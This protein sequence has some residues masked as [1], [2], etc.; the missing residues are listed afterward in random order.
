MEPTSGSPLSASL[1]FGSSHYPVQSFQGNEALSQPFHFTLLLQ[2]SDLSD[3]SAVLG[4]PCRLVLGSQR[5]ISAIITQHRLLHPY[6]PE[7]L[8][9]E[10]ELQ[11]RLSLLHLSGQPRVYTNLSARDIASM[12]LCRHG[13]DKSQL[14]FQDAWPEE[15]IIYPHWV[16]AQDESDFDF[17]Q[18]VLA[19]EGICYF[20]SNPDEGNDEYI[21][22]HDN[23]FLHPS[24]GTPFFVSSSDGLSR[25]TLDSLYKLNIKESPAS[26]NVTYSDFDP[27][28][29]SR[30]MTA[31]AGT[32]NRQV[33]V[34]GY[35]AQSFRQLQKAARHHHEQL[36]MQQKVLNA[37]SHNP[38]LM[39]GHT[40]SIMKLPAWVGGS[41]FQ[42]LELTHHF[43]KGFYHNCLTFIPKT[44]PVRP[45]PV[46]R[47]AGHMIHTA[48][49]HSDD[50]LPYLDKAGNYT[51]Y[52]HLHNPEGRRDG[53]QKAARLTPYGGNAVNKAMG[54][55]FPLRRQ[56]EVLV[57]YLHN[58]FNQPI[59]QNSPPNGLN[60]APVTRDNSWQTMLKT[61]YGQYLEFCDLK[62]KE[63]ITLANAD[64]RNR[65][66]FKNHQT[67]TP[68]IILACERGP[69]AFAAQTNSSLSSD[70][71]ITF[72]IGKDLLI[73]TTERCE[74]TAKD[75][76]LQA[77]THQLEAEDTISID[78]KRHLEVSANSL[79]IKS[80]GD[81]TLKASGNCVKITSSNG[82]VCWEVDDLKLVANQSLHLLTN[83]VGIELNAAGIIMHGQT[84]QFA[85]SPDLRGPIADSS[86]PVPPLTAPAAS[87]STKLAP[88]REY[89]FGTA[90]IIRAPN[91]E[92]PFYCKDKT[93]LIEVD[94]KGFEGNE[95]GT[96]TVVSYHY[97]EDS[98]GLP[99]NPSLNALA[100]AKTVDSQSFSLGD[101]SIYANPEQQ[102]NTPGTA[103]LRIPYS[104]DA[105]TRQ[106]DEQ[107]EV[108]HD[109]Y[110]VRIDIG[111]VQGQVYS[112]PALILSRINLTLVHD[113]DRPY[114]NHQAVVTIQ[115]ALPEAVKHHQQCPASIEPRYHQHP[116]VIENLPIGSRNR[117]TLKEQGQYRE[118]L[119]QDYTLP[120]PAQLIEVPCNP[121]E[122][123]RVPRLMP[124]IIFNLRNAKMQGN[125][126]V[127]DS[128]SPD[129][130]ILLT[131]DE[132]E[133]IKANG[134][135]IT[136][137]IHGYNV[138][139]GEFHP[140]FANMRE[141]DVVMLKS[142]GLTPMPVTTTF[143]L[144]DD[145]DTKSTIYR[146]Q[147]F[148][149][150]QFPDYSKK[151]IEE[152]KEYNPERINGNGVHEW[153]INLENNLNK[154]AG[155]DGKEYKKFTRCLFIAWPGD[156]DSP[157][158]YMTA[159]FESAR[160]GPI[161]AKVFKELQG[162][163]DGIKIN[164]I[165]HSQGNGVLLHALEKHALTNAP[166]IEHAFL[167]QAAIPSNSLSPV[168]TKNTHDLW[169]CPNAYKGANKI[170]VLH[171]RNDNILGPLLEQKD[172]PEG[173][174]IRQ[175]WNRKPI[176]EL[177]AG[178]LTQA[179]ELESMYLTANWVGVPTSELFHQETLDAAWS[180][181]IKKHPTFNCKGKAYAC[182]KTLTEQLKLLNRL[183]FQN[184]LPFEYK[185][186]L[187]N[188]IKKV[189]DRLKEY[190]E[191][192]KL[193]DAAAVG[194]ALPLLSFFATFI[195]CLIKLNDTGKILLSI[196]TPEH[197][198]L[199]EEMM[200][201]A[202][203]TLMISNV[204]EINA[205]GYSGPVEDEFIDRL[206]K[207][208]K[209]KI[210]DA[211]KWVWEHSDMK[212]PSA[213][214]LNE[215][216]KNK[217]I[218]NI[219][220]G[221]HERRRDL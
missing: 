16:Q 58:D 207:S 137:F 8:L 96:I 139:F 34:S 218:A 157:A 212:I 110:Y 39:V 169:Y 136:V 116:T 29:P 87:K 60:H 119:R 134:N 21:N 102:Q 106:A 129:A 105:I 155:F 182:Q 147:E 132:K 214:L 187:S 99:N 216:Y 40:F 35:G 82:D 167:W 104:L 113:R 74:F 4:K 213:D 125:E 130:R 71:D 150:T 121:D 54:M 47:D 37:V 56:S 57:M 190:T 166:P 161:V 195:N 202:R 191:L 127:F 97:D 11:P 163:I 156:P 176:L 44:T 179:L 15:P 100:Q 185:K 65:L 26:F 13:Y 70:D 109:P 151:R 189:Y 86:N 14:N 62:G 51:Y 68:Q 112:N 22:F 114:E 46:K 98:E 73:K 208:G 95:T 141:E 53:M 17:V 148:L 5:I 59:L 111:D 160:M 123:I 117:I 2:S 210:E 55:H 177:V 193:L 153:I 49:I 200:T 206:D 92:K 186:K 204:D 88:V 146:D 194:A 1:Q 91:W 168:R 80:D 63:S 197:N 7:S 23:F 144:V 133:Y 45:S 205:L 164:V 152:E 52:T 69:I 103:T 192:D 209:L 220:F 66:Y 165:A 33:R 76:H 19:R 27:Q 72:D 24:L 135:N 131:A 180:L 42:L 149:S 81:I 122:E 120:L 115:R 145:L 219:D 138:E 12:T 199:L 48:V 128:E 107:A 43:E 196:F 67:D 203:T 108:Y 178:L 174:K 41:G 25:P 188:G 211:T 78:A 140:H 217:I 170:T 77:E 36:T 84:I 18:R 201:F 143:L 31:Q 38:H 126:V 159:A 85:G 94:I 61:A 101:A 184:Y 154:A 75:L 32:G 172:Q 83:D 118:L 3:P 9:I 93:A 50:D 30:I 215:V 28:N 79:Q 162:A 10:L 64:S 124:P 183:S 90:K 198:R 6:N 20:W 89:S 181:W 173:V 142:T 175:V 171:S 158:D 221:F